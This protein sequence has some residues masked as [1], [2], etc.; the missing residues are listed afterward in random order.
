MSKFSPEEIEDIQLVESLQQDWLYSKA[1]L[2]KDILI[3]R[4]NVY[5]GN[6]SQLNLEAL[7]ILDILGLHDYENN[8]QKAEK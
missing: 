3:Q 7:Q 4:S 2:I 6:A 8:F 1:L 5:S